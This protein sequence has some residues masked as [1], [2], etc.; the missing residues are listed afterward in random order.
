M[1]LFC[2][3]V[4]ETLFLRS[5]FP[6]QF[7]NMPPPNSLYGRCLSFPEFFFF[8]SSSTLTEAPIARRPCQ[9]GRCTRSRPY[10]FH[11]QIRR[12][13]MFRNLV[14]FGSSMPELWA[15]DPSTCSRYSTSEVCAL[16]RNNRWLCAAYV[17]VIARHWSLTHSVFSNSKNESEPLPSGGFLFWCAPALLHRMLA[18]GENL[19][20]ST[21][22]LMIVR[23]LPF[24]LYPMTL[25]Y[26][27]RCG[28]ERR[29]SVQGGNAS[30]HNYK[31]FTAK[32]LPRI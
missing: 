11:I 25:S 8:S 20:Y 2:D 3:Y 30:A 27:L 23:L 10:L 31:S 18:E 13:L 32:P 19:P 22:N 14:L 12:Y 6:L 9:A 26:H 24:F 7:T 16:V 15:G 5:S 28:F 21:D 1:S 17:R 4:P 29:R